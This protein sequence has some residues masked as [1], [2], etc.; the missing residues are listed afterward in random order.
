ALGRCSLS[1]CNA[2]NKC[3]GHDQVLGAGYSLLGKFYF[4][5]SQAFGSGDDITAV[6]DNSGP[7]FLEP[8]QVEIDRPLADG[9]TAWKRDSCFAKSGDQRS[10]R[11]NRGSHGFYKVIG[12]LPL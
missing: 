1:V 11:Q 10:Q 3:S 7:H 8:G 6:Q 4:T 9:A 12:S 2:V 5:A